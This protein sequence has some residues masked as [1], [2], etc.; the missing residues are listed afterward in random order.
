MSW[1]RVVRGILLLDCV[2]VK[3]NRADGRLGRM[4]DCSWSAAAVTFVGDIAHGRTEPG[5]FII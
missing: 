1:G 2:A 3:E 5:H 4:A